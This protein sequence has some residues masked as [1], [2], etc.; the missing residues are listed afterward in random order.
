M[1]KYS[2]KFAII[3]KLCSAKWKQIDKID[4]NSFFRC[5]NI[6]YSV[7]AYRDKWKSIVFFMDN[8][9]SICIIPVYREGR[10]GAWEYFLVFHSSIYTDASWSNDV[11]KQKSAIIIW[12]NA[13]GGC[14][15]L[16]WRECPLSYGVQTQLK[17]EHL[18]QALSEDTILFINW[19]D[20]SVDYLMS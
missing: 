4:S 18:I 19:I 13:M 7:H 2:V 6:F 10:V 17:F 3:E 15:C 5:V 9:I 14:G 12:D 11:C 20:H 16:S 1:T 8:E